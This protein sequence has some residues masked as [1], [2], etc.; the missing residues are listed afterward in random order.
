[1]GGLQGSFE[2]WVNLQHGYWWTDE[3]LVGAATDPIRSIAGWNG[4]VGWSGDRTGDVLLCESDEARTE[5]VDRSYIEA[6]GFLFPQRFPAG[7]KLEPDRNL[8]GKRYSIVRARP[9][10]ADPVELWVSSMTGLIERVRRMTGMDKGVTVYGDFRAVDG[11]TLPFAW[12]DLGMIPGEV[13]TRIDIASVEV[14][15]TPPAGIFDPPASTLRP[16][17]FPAG[18]SSVT[19]NF[20]F[21]EGYISIPVSIN[22]MPAEE[23]GFDTGSTSTIATN[24]ARAKGLKFDAAG[25]GMGG[26]AGEAAMGMAT[27]NRIEVGGLRTTNQDVSV[28]DLPVDT[29]RGTLGYALVRSTVVQIDYASRRLTLSPPDSFRKPANAVAL[30]IRFASNSEPLVEASVDGKRGEFQLDT[31]QDMALT[32]NRPF[33]QRNG[34]I[35]KYG[36]GVKATVEGV[37]GQ[38]EAVEFTPAMFTVGGFRPSVGDADILVSGAGTAEAEHVAG[39]IGNGILKQF[40][41][42]LDYAH[43]IAYFEKNA[44]FGLPDDA[45]AETPTRGALRGDAMGGGLGLAKPG[46][47]IPTAQ[48]LLAKAIS[49]EKTQAAEKFAFREDEERSTV[50]K[51]GKALAPSRRTY[52]N[53]MLEGEVYRKLILIEGKP[54]DAKRQKQIDSDMERERTLRRADT[55]ATGRHAVRSGDLAEIARMCNSTV[56]GQELV[57]GR[58]AWRVESLPR[59]GY[60]P[61]NQEEAKFLN[62][63]RVTWFDSQEG[64]AVKFLEVFVRA[65]AGLLPGTEIERVLGKHGDAWVKDSLDWRYSLKLYGV[66]RGQGVVHVRYYDYKRFDVKSKIVDQ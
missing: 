60:K 33:A 52:D 57:S 7:I 16:L 19:V 1:V 13:I 20:D 26:G 27:V 29:W 49:I 38:G 5:A 50:D 32:V 15:K 2:S 62:A 25:V 22:G 54:P 21:S 47:P 34:L 14:G 65:T 30:P 55:A 48:S 11:L 36:A 35:A 31:G 4:K 46:S 17:E 44:A 51:N 12:Q 64:A 56:T 43:R 8:D 6:F 53:I 59:P 45:P 9:R 63:R 23:F 58:M 28:T 66:V 42:T 41:V 37:G 24:W 18:R 39:S 10:G 61:A 40:T 3:Q